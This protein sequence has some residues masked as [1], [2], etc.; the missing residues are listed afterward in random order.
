[1]EIE[2][3][4]PANGVRT[5]LYREREIPSSRTG[6][7]WIGRTVDKDNVFGAQTNSAL[8]QFLPYTLP[9]PD[10]KGY[11]IDPIIDSARIMLT[12]S[13]V[14][15]D[16]TVRQTFEVWQVIDEGGSREKLDRDSTYYLNF[17]IDDYKER[18]LFTFEHEGHR[19]VA[20]RLFPTAAGREYLYSLVS[21][22]DDDWDTYITDSL[23]LAKY[24][25]LIIT[26]A[27]SPTMAAALYGADLTASGLSLHV[28]NHDTIDRNAIYDTLTTFFSFRDTDT[29][30]STYTSAAAWDNVSINVASFDYTG[31]DLGALESSTN[32]FTDTLP[33]VT[34]MTKLYVQSMGG[35]GT[36]LR[37]TDELID[38]IRNLRF[39][40]GE[41]STT[42]GKRDIAINQAMM[43]IWLYSTEP[44]DAL[45]TIDELDAA[46]PRLGSYLNMK[47]L[48]PIPDY[49]YYNESYRNQQ[50]AAQGSSSTYSLPYGGYLNR[51]NG[52]YELDITSYIQQLAKVKADDPE[53]RYMSPAIFLA[54]E[55]YS[56]IGSGQ[57]MLHGFGSSKPVSIRITYTIIE[58]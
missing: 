23:F 43:K 24:R 36:Y 57:G 26:P 2:V 48:T 32:Q 10:A 27:G 50:L 9:Y 29:S 30:A 14:R 37:F 18:L 49:Q 1:M 16:T 12:L 28:R 38:E 20:A 53:Y 39:S 5:Y 3:T 4:N 42:E 11:G 55:A 40:S 34:P 51:S 13:G 22:K 54:P 56:I 19:D 8:L 21:M 35:V 31:S 17:P 41:S 52:Y 58:G 25:G 6:V 15:G 47:T 7:A 45:P 46:L 44:D 33:T